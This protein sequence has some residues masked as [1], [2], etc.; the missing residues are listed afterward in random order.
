MARSPW[1][2]VDG[3]T[4]TWNAAAG[5]ASARRTAALAATTLARHVMARLYAPA[6]EPRRIQDGALGGFGA[7]LAEELLD[8]R[9]EICG[10][11]ELIATGLGGLLDLVLLGSAALE[12]PHVL[13]DLG[14][15]PHDLGGISPEPL[16]R[17]DQARENGFRAQQL[18]GA[19]PKGVGRPRI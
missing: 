18:E 3:V 5:A 15:L 16:G 13:G 9:H 1:G 10:R 11:R 4:V 6:V 17:L 7:L 12:L 8:L 19:A 14:V 2:R